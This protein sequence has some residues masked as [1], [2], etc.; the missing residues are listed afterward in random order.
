VGRTGNLVIAYMHCSGESDNRFDSK[1]GGEAQGVICKCFMMCGRVYVI[2]FNLRLDIHLIG[3][4]LARKCRLHV[5][6]RASI[7]AI[8]L[9]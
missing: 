7:A 3:V 8:I 5:N 9:I 1:R 4:L 6:I 2:N